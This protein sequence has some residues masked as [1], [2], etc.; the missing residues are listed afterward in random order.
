MTLRSCAPFRHPDEGRARTVWRVLVPL[1]GT[2]ASLV[3]LDLVF[4]QPIQDRPAGYLVAA[5]GRFAVA[6]GIIG[7]TARWL[8]RRRLRD[9]GLRGD[10]WW[11]TD[12]AAGAVTGLAM[13]AASAGVGIAGGWLEVRAILPSVAAGGTWTILALA[14]VRLA[15]VGF[16]EELV[17]RG[18]MI[19][20]T[21]EGLGRRRSPAVAV[22]IASLISTAVFALIHVPQHLGTDMPLGRM[23]LMWVLLGALLALPYVLTGQLGFSIGLHLT[24]NLALQHVFVQW[25]EVGAGATVLHLEVVEGAEGIAGIGGWLQLLAIVLAYGAVLAWIRWRHGRLRIDPSLVRSPSPVERSD[26]QGS[27]PRTAR[28]PRSV[29]AGCA[30]TV[31][32]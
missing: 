32:R 23:A 5:G 25:G 4:V 31:R 17:F 10:G 15:A 22:T 16:W 18:V 21:A 1:V 9:Y 14:T 7:M 19:C 29:G 28:S 30:T 6:F 12:L 3:V 24:V 2:M 27:A 20:N 8:D 26:R 11:W 13:F